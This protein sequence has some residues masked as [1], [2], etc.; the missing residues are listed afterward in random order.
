MPLPSLGVAAELGLGFAEHWS[1]ALLGGVGLEQERV[2]EAE[3]RIFL[4]V[5]SGVLRGCYAPVALHSSRLS[6]CTGA[7]L[8]WI[9]GHGSGFD[10]SRSAS[11]V[12]LAPLLAF[13]FS[14]NWPTFV[15]WHAE[16]EGSVPLS[17]QRFLVE[18]EEVARSDTSI[19]SLRLGP[20]VR[21]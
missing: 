8:L 18:G 13:D 3:R 5:F 20:V 4:R 9:R 11:L 2:L 12:A 17:R 10:I 16:L 21:F 6:V 1:I 15:E 7:Q 19:F 14:M